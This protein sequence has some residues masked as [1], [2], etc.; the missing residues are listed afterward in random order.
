MLDLCLLGTGG[1]MPLHNRWLTSL[2]LR[3]NGKMILLDC[4]EATQIPFRQAGFG[5]I[6]LDA[7]LFTHYHADH[8]AGLPGML[9]T[10][11][12][13]GRQEPL[14]LMGPK[15]IETVVR[16][17]LILAQHLSFRLEFIPVDERPFPLQ[18]GDFWVDFYYVDHNV[19]C[20][21]YQIMIKR[22]GKF[23]LEKAKQHEVPLK[24]W[25]GLQKGNTLFHEG[26]EYT[27]QMVLGEERKGIK[28]SYCTDTRPLKGLSEF[29]EDSD[30]FICE[31]MYGDDDSMQKAKHK[32]HMTFR[33]AA[34]IAKEARVKELWLTHFSPSLNAPWEFIDNAKKVFSNSFVGKDLMKKTIFFEE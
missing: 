30:L 17:L 22:G 29:V 18:I 5:V 11:Q 27:P 13:A 8:I 15:G 12:N 10:M 16:S 6:H 7:I 23:D 14:I 32:K 3:C 34:T 4:G 19:R 20:V 24:L 33:E 31:G 2:L 28:V 9:L 26:R 25:N 21:A 1:M